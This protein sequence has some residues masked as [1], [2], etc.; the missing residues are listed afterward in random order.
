MTVRSGV[1][2]S[3]YYNGSRVGRCRKVD[4]NVERA[5]LRTTKQGDWDETYRNGLRDTSVTGELL[6]DPEDTVAINLINSIWND[7]SATIPCT[8]Q[9]DDQYNRSH[10]A[11][12]LLTRVGISMAYGDAHVVDIAFRVSGKPTGAF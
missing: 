2:G 10:T 9:W 7:S 11:N 5:T 8:F 3:L 6:Y 1:N 4:L 12:V